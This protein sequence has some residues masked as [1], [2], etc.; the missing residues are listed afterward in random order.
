MFKCIDIPIIAASSINYLSAS[1][2]FSYGASAIGIGS[3]ISNYDIINDMT[4]Y[5]YGILCSIKAS[6]SKSIA[7]PHLL[8]V[9][10]IK[11]IAC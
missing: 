5:I 1:I 7:S 4:M 8:H 2:A 6:S 9:N 10:D 3:A 11:Y